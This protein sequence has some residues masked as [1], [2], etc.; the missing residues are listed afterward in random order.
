MIDTET[1]LPSP[2]PASAAPAASPPVPPVPLGPGELPLERLEAGICTLAG[3][4]A[5]GTCRWLLL[6]A[7]FDRRGLA[8]V[9]A[10]VVRGV[11]VVEVRAVATTAH[12]HVRV[13]RA[14]PGLPGVREAFAAG[15]LSFA[16][17]RALTR[18]VTAASEQGWLG[19]AVSA[20]PPRAGGGAGRGGA[21]ELALRR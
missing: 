1:R 16:K 11:V 9:G 4:L 13:A 8:V 14:L 15:R 12:E 2:E 10:G 21:A 7:E 20:A 17:A 19:V 3:H 5:A 6:V 18:V